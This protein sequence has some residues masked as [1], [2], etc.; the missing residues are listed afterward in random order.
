MLCVCGGAC[1]CL[2]L[3]A[4]V[5]VCYY[6]GLCVSIPISFLR[7][8]SS[9]ERSH[10]VFVLC[11]LTYCH[12]YMV[13]KTLQLVLF[14]NLL[15]S[16]RK[17]LLWGVDVGQNWILTLLSLEMQYWVVYWERVVLSCHSEKLGEI[18][19]CSGELAENGEI[20]EKLPDVLILRCG[21]IILSCITV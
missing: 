11:L 4:C 17:K 8:V 19:L 2:C 13:C 9:R 7:V 3:H 14:I 6:M 21:G 5:C 16:V 12:T 20:V 18:S 15:F 1:A 10:C